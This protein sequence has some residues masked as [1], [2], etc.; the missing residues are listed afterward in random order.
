[1]AGDLFHDS[2]LD[3]ADKLDSHALQESD[4]LEKK[5]AQRFKQTPQRS[6]TGK[7]S[8]RSL[9]MNENAFLS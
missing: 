6:A 7:F 8:S 4:K 9:E 1:M 2:M 5:T 3:L